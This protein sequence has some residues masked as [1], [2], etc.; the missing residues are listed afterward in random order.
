MMALSVCMLGMAVVVLLCML[1]LKQLDESLKVAF[2]AIAD[3]PL[4]LRMARSLMDEARRR[5]DELHEFAERLEQQKESVI[6]AAVELRMSKEPP[7]RPKRVGADLKSGTHLPYL[8]RAIAA[9]D[10]FGVPGALIELGTGPSSTPVFLQAHRGALRPSVHVDNDLDW[11]RL[12]VPEA[13][14]SHT[15][16]ITSDWRIDKL[17]T[18]PALVLVDVAPAEARPKLVDHYLTAP[19][20]IVH[21][22]ERASHSFYQWSTEWWTERYG[23]VSGVAYWEDHGVGTTVLANGTPAFVQA[24]LH[25]VQLSLPEVP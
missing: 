3:L 9:I 25:G 14:W 22:T 11:L 13:R 21:D 15:L 4:E 16:C 24:V 8:Q 12:Q 17:P 1:K 19:V 23:Q 5:G 10:A 2:A 7:S 6:E 18:K 20:V